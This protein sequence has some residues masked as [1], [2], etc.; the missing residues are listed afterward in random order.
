M[1][2]SIHGIMILIL[3]ITKESGV[4]YD[5]FIEEVKDKF[6]H[7][8]HYHN[9]PGDVMSLDEMMVYIEKLGRFS[10]SSEKKI[11]II[12]YQGICTRLIELNLIDA[13]N[14]GFNKILSEIII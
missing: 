2:E 1:S 6:G 3:L 13:S 11:T 4:D 8:Q 5:S 9:C 10:L 7:N 12:D 14:I